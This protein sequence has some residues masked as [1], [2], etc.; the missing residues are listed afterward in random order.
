[1]EEDGTPDPEQKSLL[2]GGL[3]QDSGD[4]G[5]IESR[6]RAPDQPH[7]AQY[8]LY[9]S[10]FLSAWGARMW[11]FAIGLVSYKYSTTVAQIRH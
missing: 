6:D 8:C 1:M 10:H 3:Q 9:G 11:E 2:G 4:P 7:R 5:E